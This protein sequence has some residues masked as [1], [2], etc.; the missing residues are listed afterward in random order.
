MGLSSGRS[1]LLFLS[2]IFLLFVVVTALVFLTS[3]SHN[4]GPKTIYFKKGTSSWK[5]LEQLET[6]GVIRNK[7]LFFGTVVVLGKKGRIKAGEYEFRSRIRPLQVL[8]A[9]VKGDVKR[10]LITIAEGLTVAQIARVIQDC[11]VS[12][13][14]GFMEKATS[15]EFISSLGLPDPGES[16][17]EGYLFPETYTLVRDMDP[18]EII[19]TMVHQF[20]K[21]FGPEMK[22]RIQEMGLTARQAVILASIIEKE[23]SLSSEKPLVSAVLYNRLKKKMLLQ[24]DPTVIYG[25]PNFNG[26]LTKQ[27]LQTPTPYNTY[28]THGLPPTPICNPGKESFIAA[29]HPASVPYLYFVSK[30]D[31]SHFFSSSLDEHE[32][33][34]WIYQ[35]S[36]R[37]N[38]LTKN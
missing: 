32:K 23:T 24:S 1:R 16:T 25:I 36:P 18:E 10:H 21:V 26:D 11:C 29:V 7:Y 17:L 20:K 34:V 4:S 14:K 12:G 22:E 15:R 13:S 37:K 30:N 33:A 6:E 19:R 3:P 9:L 27:D 35:K 8:E 2:S 38:R 31:G 28:V 5:V